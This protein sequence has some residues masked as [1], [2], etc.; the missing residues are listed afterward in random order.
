MSTEPAPAVPVAVVVPDAGHRPATGMVAPWAIAAVVVLLGVILRI[1]FFA[2]YAPTSLTRDEAALCI[3]LVGVDFVDLTRPLSHDQA[4]P[5]GFMLLEKLVTSALGTGEVA[6][7]SLSLLASIVLLPVAYLVFRRLISPAGATIGLALLSV[8]ETLIT[9]GATFKQYEFDALVTVLLLLAAMPGLDRAPGYRPYALFAVVGAISVWFSFPAAFV[10][11]GIGLTL[12]AMDLVG[13]RTRS[14]F[15]WAVAS[16]ACGLSFGAAYLLLYRHYSGSRY[17][18]EWWTY[19]FVP[20]PPR[21][22]ADLKWYA[23]NFLGVFGLMS[24]REQGLAAATA[25]F[26]VYCL[27]RQP[28]RRVSALLL[29][30]P[31]VL[32][33]AASAMHLYPFGD[34]TMLFA[35][36]LLAAAVGAGI[37][38]LA[39]LQRGRGPVLASFMLGALLLYPVYVDLKYAIDPRAR[40]YQDVKPVISYIAENWKEGDVLFVNWDAETLYDYYGNRQDF[41]G[42]SRRPVLHDVAPAPKSRRKEHLVWYA[43]QLKLIEGRRRVWF[44]FGI[45]GPDEADIVLE[46]LDRRGT[47]L[48]S[49]QE[50]GAAAYCFEFP[51]DVARALAPAP[52]DDRGL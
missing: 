38:E 43:E 40:L 37:G 8:S 23:D 44:L 41:R 27:C 34:R 29:L 51:S 21:S 5:V 50:I 45:A 10:I 14:M 17:L 4:A 15:L 26:G 47:C 32:T 25:I 6:L 30:A 12:M 9:G 39:A 11:G 46:L 49:R 2:G 33:L 3:N 36:P 42:M 7:R 52:H 28:E 16:A 18:L 31:I 24:L 22:L 13:G 19:A 35:V 1:R 48:A 20:F